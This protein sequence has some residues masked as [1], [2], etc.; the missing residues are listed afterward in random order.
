MSNTIRIWS[1]GGDALTEI[2]SQTVDLESRL[3]DWMESDVSVLSDDLL[4]IGRQLD[5]DGGGILD[6]L[7]LD[8]VGDLVLVE[9]KR[10]KTP[11][12]V[13]AQALDYAAWVAALSYEA[14]VEIGDRTHG[15]AGRLEAAFRARF[16]ADLP[17]VVN[18]EH[19]LLVVAS[20]VDPQSERIIRYLSETHGV[21]INAVTFNYF[22]ADDGRELLARTH[23]IEPE[24]A[25][26]Q[27]ARKAGSKRRRGT[28]VEVHRERAER[29]GLVHLFDPLVAGLSA[30]FSLYA[31]TT[32]IT[33]GQRGKWLAMVNVLTP[34]SAEG[35]GL[36]FNVYRHRL[37]QAFGLA[38]DAV[39]ALLPDGAEPWAY[40]A[41][42]SDADDEW[43]GYTGAFQDVA[44]VDRFLARLAEAPRQPAG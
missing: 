43:S 41:D 44:E 19:R 40:A 5:T 36:R 29:L 34:Q 33:A 28:T 20:E 15:G 12:D 25:E 42:P 27:Q 38:P 6:L 8:R 26:G 18:A 21:P 22:R 3:E 11:R 30:W 10:G 9:L 1:V 23:L 39:R 37:A 4:V 7:C 17:D 35:E 31:G 2:P 24:A 13:V 16:D 32:M 14:V